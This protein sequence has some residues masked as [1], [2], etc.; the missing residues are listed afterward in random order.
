MNQTQQLLK[1][2]KK[3]LR[4]NGVTYADIGL[5]LKLSEASI[6]RLF[7]EGSF[8]LVRFEQV[9]QLAGLGFSELIDI[10]HK[11]RRQLEQLSLEQEK[12]IAADLLLLL[13]AVSVMNGMSFADLLEHYAISEFECLQKIAQ[14]DRLKFLELLPRNRIRMLISPNFRWR[15][16]GPIQ[17]FFHEK[18][19]A[20]FFNSKFQKNTEKLL[21]LNGI[22]SKTTNKLLQEKMETFALEFSDLIKKDAALPTSEKKGNTFVFALREWQFGLFSKLRRA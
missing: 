16:N 11:E 9:C 12:Q 6:K 8:S 10:N 15:Q 1:T 7:A 4:A 21:V 20:E 14:L 17:S 19:V 22:C 3:Q 13:I 2:L 18:V 5:H